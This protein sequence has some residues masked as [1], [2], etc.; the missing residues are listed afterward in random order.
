M[1]FFDINEISSEELRQF[2]NLRKM[3]LM[4]SNYNAVKAIL[5]KNNIEAERL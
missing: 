2:K 4:T 1:P 3:T 5:E